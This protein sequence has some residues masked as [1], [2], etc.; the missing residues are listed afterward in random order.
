MK[1]Y[2]LK[3]KTKKNLTHYEHSGNTNLPDEMRRIE[4]KLYE[5]ITDYNK[6]KLNKSCRNILVTRVRIDSDF[7]LF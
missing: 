7:L 3:V 1:E 4:N 2:W 5:I 6:E